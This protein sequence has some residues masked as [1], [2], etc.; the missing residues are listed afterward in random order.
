MTL[1]EFYD[2]AA[3]ENIAGALLCRPDRMILLGD[4]HKQMERSR[5]LYRGVLRRKGIETEIVCRTVNK[6]DLAGIVSALSQLV[7]EHA[8][9]LFDLTGGEDLYLVA[10]GVVMERY[11]GRVRCHRFNLQNETVTDCDM[12]G[13]VCARSPVDISVEDHVNLYG[14]RVVTD[15]IGGTPVFSWTF[16]SDFV[17]D[18]EDMWR[19]CRRD[20]SRW[21]AHVGTLGSICELLHGGDPLSICFDK[22]DVQQALRRRRL[23]Y[24]WSEP[25]MRALAACGL[26]HAYT[27]RGSRVSFSFKS[28]QVKRSLTVSGQVL[29]LAVACA[30][31]AAVDKE[32]KPLYND[33]RVGVVI[34][35]DLLDG[36]EPYETVNEID[37][38]AMRGTLPVF[39]SCKNGWFDVNELYKLSTVAD[40]FGKGYAK[41]ALVS[42][43][44][45]SFGERADYLRARMADM[46]IRSIE[47]T[48]KTDG[49][50]LA[51][52]LKLC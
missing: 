6:N 51:Q 14:G 9:C 10:L 49:T 1:I 2:K 44:M 46:D 36:D 7:E 4:R 12:D 37:V 29:E 47:I 33:V 39:V 34:D 5:A 40:R 31:R 11:P 43:A 42:T 18:V 32:G 48:D 20:P 30:M 41:K 23:R 8:D 35:W 27:E 26:I 17:R 52:A 19:I 38:F 24:E 28:E 21:N 13:T 3:I 16:S 15:Q 50:A 45:G 22:Q 25:L